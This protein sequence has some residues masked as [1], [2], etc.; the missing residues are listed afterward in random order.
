MGEGNLWTITASTR[1]KPTSSI[2]N[3][4]KRKGVTLMICDASKKV[5]EV[6]Q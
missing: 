4:S 3:V 1:K 6:S 5:E 2:C